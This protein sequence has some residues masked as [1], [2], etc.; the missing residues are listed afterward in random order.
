MRMAAA[1]RMSVLIGS[2]KTPDGEFY[3][4]GGR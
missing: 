1:A 3:R 2:L 4:A